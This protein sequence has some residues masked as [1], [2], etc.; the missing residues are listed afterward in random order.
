MGNPIAWQAEFDGYQVL[1]FLHEH[2]VFSVLVVRQSD[3]RDLANLRYDSAFEAACAAIPGL[4]DWTDPD[5]SRPITPVLPGGNLLNH[6]RGQRTPEGN[7]VLPGLLFLGDA[8]CTTTPIFGRGIATCFMQAQ[9]MLRLL[10]EGGPDPAVAEAFDDWSDREMRPW[11]EDHVRMDTAMRDRWDGKGIDLDQ[12]LPSDLV[13]AAA[14]ID[15]SIMAAAQ[16]Y[17]AMTAGPTSIQSLQDRAKA[18]YATGWRNPLSP[19]PSRDELAAIVL[20]S[21]DSDTMA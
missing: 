4:S 10:D 2:G 19:G 11:V 17:L 7:L 20:R 14:E 9:E 5:R 21:L 16:P 13:L 1:V 8:V 12:P 3:D 15:P 6:Y 18:V